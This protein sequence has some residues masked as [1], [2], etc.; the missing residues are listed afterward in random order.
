MS[1][2]GEAHG[3]LWSFCA[4]HDLHLG[5]SGTGIW[6]NRMLFDR[7][8]SLL[9]AALAQWQADP[10]DFALFLGDLTNAGDRESFARLAERT[11]AAPCPLYPAVGNHDAVHHESRQWL[12][13]AIPPPALEE[14]WIAYDFVHRGLSFVVLDVAWVAADGTESPAYEAASRPVGMTVPRPLLPWLDRTLAAHAPLPTI[15]CTH[16]P[17]LPL[18]AERIRRGARDAGTLH[19]PER[20]LALL[21]RHPHVRAV[22]AGHLHLAQVDRRCGVVHAT[23]AALVEWPH[24]YRRF[25]V[26]ADAVRVTAHTCADA[27]TQAESLIPGHEWAAGSADEQSYTIPLTG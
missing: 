11:R 4:I 19:Q 1:T 23:G 2:A 20:V 21:D 26:F 15:V 14:G 16:Y 17:L 22:L 12:V 7:A 24:A 10:P 3:P 18:R 25:A 27:A 9:A 13:E 8:E 6:N 5:G